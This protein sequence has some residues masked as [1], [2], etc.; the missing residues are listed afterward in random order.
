MKSLFLHRRLRPYYLSL[1]LLLERCRSDTEFFVIILITWSVTV[2]FKLTLIF[3]NTDHQLEQQMIFNH[4]SCHDHKTSESRLS[5]HWRDLTL[6]PS[7]QPEWELGIS[8]ARESRRRVITQLALYVWSWLGSLK[9]VIILFSEPGPGPA[10]GII[11][12]QA[13]NWVAEAVTLIVSFF[14]LNCWNHHLWHW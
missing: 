6:I 4:P 7:D 13:G 10:R 3:I 5:C 1:R 11:V 12:T 9:S 2:T 8:S 14:F